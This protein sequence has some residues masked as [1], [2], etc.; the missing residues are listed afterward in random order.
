MYTANTGV[1]QITASFPCGQRGSGSASTVHLPIPALELNPL[2]SPVHAAHGQPGAL[3]RQHH[4]AVAL[5]VVHPAERGSM[6]VNL[7]APIVIGLTSRR[8]VQVI[9]GREMPLTKVI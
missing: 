2:P 9:L 3:A 5:V 7:R 1:S 4:V 8:G 6:T